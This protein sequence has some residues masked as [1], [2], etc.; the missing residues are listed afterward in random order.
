MK[1]IHFSFIIFVVLL[2]TLFLWNEFNDFSSEE[3][4]N[5]EKIGNF[6]SSLGAIA[7][8]VSIYFLYKQLIEMDATRR[9]AYH[10]DLY[11]SQTK[12][13]TQNFYYESFGSKPKVHISK[14]TIYNEKVKPYITLHNIGLGAAKNIRIEWKYD[15]EAVEN[16]IKETYNY[17]KK[18]RTES[19]HLDFLPAN[20]KI[21]IKIPYFY[22]NCYGEFLNQSISM[23]LLTQ[24]DVMKP[25]LSLEISYQD[26]QDNIVKKTFNVKISAFEQDLNLKFNMR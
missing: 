22:L 20:S 12:L 5:D 7:A 21:Q 2:F 14:L 3:K 10:P 17:D 25:L 8:A 16:F 4:I 1:K 18:Q 24:E 11:P 15:L 6:F 13:K 26:I 23:V 9:S 19:E